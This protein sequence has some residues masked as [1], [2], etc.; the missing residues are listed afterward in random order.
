[1]RKHEGAGTLKSPPVDLSNFAQFHLSEIE[2]G[3]E[4]FELAPVGASWDFQ[5]SRLVDDLMENV[6]SSTEVDLGT[7]PQRRLI[8]TRSTRSTES[9]A[10]G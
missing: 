1:M 6:S 8:T 7:F 4:S 2:P 10:R 3:F 5:L 9:A